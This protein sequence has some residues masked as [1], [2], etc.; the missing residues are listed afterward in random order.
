[1][2]VYK[3]LFE[4]YQ[5]MQNEGAEEPVELVWGVGVARWAPKGGS[6]LIDHPVIEVRVELEM[7]MVT[8]LL[9]LDWDITAATSC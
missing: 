3:E 2:R 8:S 6:E 4:L 7:C 9:H 1:M 5:R